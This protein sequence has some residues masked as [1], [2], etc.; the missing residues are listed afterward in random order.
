MTK[1]I[2]DKTRIKSGFE[3]LEGSIEMNDEVPQQKAN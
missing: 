2:I 1:Q 3:S